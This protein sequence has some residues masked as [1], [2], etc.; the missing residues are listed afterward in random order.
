MNII[1]KTIMITS[2]IFFLL[3]S[4]F[5]K[6][7]N[8]SFEKFT[9]QDNNFVEKN[10]IPICCSW[11]PELQDRTL[12]YSIQESGNNDINASESVTKA[13]DL[14]NKNLMGMNIVKVNNTAARSSNEDI[15]I[16]FIKD[17]KEVAGKTINSID[18]NGFIRKSYIIL[19]K[20]YFNHPFNK[21]QLIQIAKHEL[22]HVLGL[23]HVKFN[24]NL[25]SAQVN[26]GSTTISPC[27]VEAVETANSWKLKEDSISIH[28]PIQNYVVCK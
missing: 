15:K 4:L 6:K 8:D 14:W 12:T 25:M 16:S 21:I 18:S 5:P 24:G 23:N 9:E 10:M 20:E 26:K 2:F 17:G 28:S 22:G 3:I 7:F 13:V 27:L 11:G 19:S 1:L